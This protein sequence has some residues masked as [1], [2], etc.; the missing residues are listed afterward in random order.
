MPRRLYTAQGVRTLPGTPLTTEEAAQIAEVDSAVEPVLLHRCRLG[1]AQYDWR[2]TATVGRFMCRGC[3]ISALCGACAEIA[4]QCVSPGVV[5]ALCALHGGLLEIGIDAVALA[6]G[7]PAVVVPRVRRPRPLQ[8]QLTLLTS[9][10]AAERRK[11]GVDPQDE[12]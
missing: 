4:G 8:G 6:V 11:E 3:G 5:L 12:T 9:H 2:A 7:F 10:Q 1:R